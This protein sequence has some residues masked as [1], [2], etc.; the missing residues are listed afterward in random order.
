MFR[1]MAL[2]TSSVVLGTYLV[3]PTKQGLA[4]Q[5]R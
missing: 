4:S 1:K 5:N 2:S 3:G